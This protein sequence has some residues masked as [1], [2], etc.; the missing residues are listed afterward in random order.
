MQILGF[1]EG[2]WLLWVWCSCSVSS[3]P[4]GGEA[5]TR[6]VFIIVFLSASICPSLALPQRVDEGGWAWVGEAWAFADLLRWS[7]MG[8][9]ITVLGL[10]LDYSFS[11]ISLDHLRSTECETVRSSFVF[12]LCLSLCILK[13]E[14]KREASLWEG[15]MLK[16]SFLGKTQWRMASY[17]QR[18]W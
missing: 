5:L 6:W 18:R 12:V 4:W 10:H 1:S 17:T 3:G 7:R 2:N 9:K 13:L 16:L 15:G 8:V 11:L 14:F